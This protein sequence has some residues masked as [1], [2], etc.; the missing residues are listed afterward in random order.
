MKAIQLDNTLVEGHAA[1]GY[2]VLFND[3]DWLGAEREL[4]QAIKLNP[5]SSV[6]HQRYGDVLLVGD[7]FDESI[8][9]Y[10]RATELDPVSGAVIGDLAYSL[11]VEHR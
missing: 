8:A 5:N 11:L 3:W 6:S 10:K 2:A 4:K 7:R 9:E 1:L